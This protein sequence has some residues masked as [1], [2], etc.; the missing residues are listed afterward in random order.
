PE[1]KISAKKV[2]F[3][4]CSSETRLERTPIGTMHFVLAHLERFSGRTLDISKSRQRKPQ[5]KKKMDHKNCSKGKKT[6]AHKKR[7]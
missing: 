1:K 2:G 5:K 4:K 7:K 3:E 6:S